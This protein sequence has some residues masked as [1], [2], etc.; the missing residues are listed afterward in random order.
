MLLYTVVGKS[1]ASYIASYVEH[2]S[3]YA[4]LAK[5]KDKSAKSMNLATKCLISGCIAV[6]FTLWQS[7][8]GLAAIS[9]FD[10][11]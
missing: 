1:R 10:N 9:C 6:G 7:W 5:M 11:G 8:I 3:K 2:K 4:V